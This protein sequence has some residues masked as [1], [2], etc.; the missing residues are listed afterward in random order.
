MNKFEEELYA[1][2]AQELSSKSP[3]PGVMAKAIADADG[4]EKK[5]FSRYIALRVEHLKSE[6]GAEI[7]RQRKAE[8]QLRAEELRAENDALKAWRRSGILMGKEDWRIQLTA[9][10]LRFVETKTREN[11]TL[12]PASG[13]YKVQFDPDAFV[14]KIVLTNLR[15][16]SFSF[17]A[18]SSTVES[19]RTWWNKVKV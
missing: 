15:G 10:G 13:D 4:D 14:H 16:E 1:Q 18:S 12:S 17:N 2:A 11:L 6:I 7:I 8:A 3:V 9:S 5:V 19:V